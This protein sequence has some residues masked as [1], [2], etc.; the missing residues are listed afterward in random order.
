MSDVD[1]MRLSRAG[2]MEAFSA[3]VHRHQS[4]LL[5]FFLRL[6][7]DAHG[8]EDCAQ[9]TFLRLYR[10]RGHYQPSAPFRSFLFTLARHSWV[11]WYRRAARREAAD[12]DRL[13]ICA[14][15]SASGTDA[16]LDLRSALLTLPEHLRWV[17]ALSTDEGLSYAEIGAVLGI[18]VGTVKSRMF[19]ALKKL[20]ETLHAKLAR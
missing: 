3:L 12:I 18:P 20:R 9:E 19:H 16:R 7:A 13:E 2:E 6:G 11:D 14:P 17:I 10:C 5:N 1:L 4:A 8:A 15:E